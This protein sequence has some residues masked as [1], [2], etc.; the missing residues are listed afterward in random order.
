MPTVTLDAYILPHNQRLHR[1]AMLRNPGMD[2]R[3]AALGLPFSNP[4]GLLDKLDN[5]VARLSRTGLST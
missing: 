3:A 5:T 1:P 4:H 2:A